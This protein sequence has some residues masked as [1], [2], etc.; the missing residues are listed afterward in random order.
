MEI[1][2]LES[3]VKAGNNKPNPDTQLEG[4]CAS[5][6]WDKPRQGPTIA[7]V[8]SPLPS[9]DLTTTDGRHAVDDRKD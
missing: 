1:L 5:L 3:D 4:A 6:S 8:E 2:K 7:V 9:I